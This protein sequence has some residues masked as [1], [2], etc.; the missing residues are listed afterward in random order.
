M[1]ADQGYETIQGVSCLTACMRN[2]LNVM[3]IPIDETHMMLNSVSELVY[4]KELFFDQNYLEINCGSGIDYLVKNCDISYVNELYLDDNELEF[5]EE[6]VENNQFLTLLVDAKSLTYSDIFQKSIGTKHAINVIGKKNNFFCIS[7][8]FIPSRNDE[9]F[10]GYISEE[11]IIDAWKKAGKRYYL[12]DF[13]KYVPRQDDDKWKNEIKK[14]LELYLLGG[15]N[16]SKYYGKDAME[17]FFS[18][19]AQKYEKDL[20]MYV[21]CLKS[22]S[23]VIKVYGVY[24]VRK[25]LVQALGKYHIAEKNGRNAYIYDA[26]EKI[27]EEWDNMSLYAMY[28]MTNTKYEKYKMFMDKIQRLSDMEIELF[29]EIIKII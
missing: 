9:L 17:C 27:K 7:D 10:Q 21:A 26:A 29:H 11:T 23:Y 6:C 24:A 4:N 2:Y 25:L 14:H 1:L 5:I 28:A 15:K 3:K 22:I 20:S 13:S 8:G 19:I 18:D 12:W 16:G